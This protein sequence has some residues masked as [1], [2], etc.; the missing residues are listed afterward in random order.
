MRL[1]GDWL[2]YNQVKKNEV[3]S[4]FGGGFAGAIGDVVGD[5]EGGEHGP[6][7][8]FAFWTELQLRFPVRGFKFLHGFQLGR[9]DGIVDDFTEQFGVAVVGDHGDV[10]YHA[11]GM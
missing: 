1:D 6:D 3:M 8:G 11:F 2:F 9:R 10:F 7:G 4:G 5:A